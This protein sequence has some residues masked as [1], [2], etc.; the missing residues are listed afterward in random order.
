MGYIADFLVSAGGSL[1]AAEVW[2]SAHSF[3]Q[4]LT[5]LA[6]RCL[7]SEDRERYREEWLA[8]LND[9]PGMLAKF[10]WV[11]GCFWTAMAASGR[12]WLLRRQVVRRRREEELARERE[13]ISKELDEL[14]A[15]L[16]RLAACRT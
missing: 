13:R 4:S 7:P 1:F 10:C 12:A 15:S 11:G 8:D 16:D 3:A 9:M 14:Q 6:V 2:A 5:R